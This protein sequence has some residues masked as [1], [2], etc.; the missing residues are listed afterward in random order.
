M[1]SELDSLSQ[2]ANHVRDQQNHT[3]RKQKGSRHSDA[4]VEIIEQIEKRG[5]VSLV[6]Y[7]A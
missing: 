6:D 7:M 1:G 4:E 2:S 3:K 5:A